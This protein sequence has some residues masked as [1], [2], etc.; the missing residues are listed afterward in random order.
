MLQMAAC[1]AMMCRH[2]CRHR[3]AGLVTCSCKSQPCAMPAAPGKCKSYGLCQE[4][5]MERVAAFIL[6]RKCEALAL[7]LRIL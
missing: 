4:V 6:L 7:R 2:S 3:A 5:G 1:V